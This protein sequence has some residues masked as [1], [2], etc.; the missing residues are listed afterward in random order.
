MINPIGS[1]VPSIASLSAPGSGAARPQTGGSSFADVFGV[2]AAV[3]TDSSGAHLQIT[4]AAGSSVLVGSDPAFD[5]ERASTATDASLTVDGISITSATNSV[6]GAVPDLT[7]SL[8]G[9]TAANSPASLTVGANTSQINQAL[10]SFVSDYNSA[11]TLVN[12]QFAYSITAGSQGVLSGD[13]TVRSLQNELLG[14][15]GYSAGSGGAS[16]SIHSLADLGI[17]MND[18]G[19]LSLNTTELDGA[20]ANPSAVQSFFQGTS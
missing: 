16:G 17:T 2:T 7:L 5:L 4:A 10:S 11:L 18:D 8:S 20:E 19:S 15:V 6:T 1:G 14:A 3:V 13:S 12:S 9:I